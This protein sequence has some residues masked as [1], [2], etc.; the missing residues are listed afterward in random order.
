MIQQAAAALSQLYESDETGWLEAMADLDHAGIGP[1]FARRR[2]VRRLNDRVELAEHSYRL[3]H[4][5][6]IPIT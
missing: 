1:H 3:R 2:P 4:G 5:P 6:L